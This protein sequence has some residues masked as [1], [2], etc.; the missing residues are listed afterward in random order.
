MVVVVEHCDRL[1]RFG[2][3]HLTASMAACG[4]RVVVLEESETLETIS[5]LV[6]G[7]T[8]VLA[9]LCARLYGQCSASRRA[10]DAVATGG[11]R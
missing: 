4:R 8:G 11:Q 2:F 9:G 3:G 7:V 5:D 1:T 10:A 6:G